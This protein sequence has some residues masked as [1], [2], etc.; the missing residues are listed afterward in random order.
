MHS[1]QQIV[2]VLNASETWFKAFAATVRFIISGSYEPNSI[3]VYIKLQ[4]Q[5]KLIDVLSI[6]EAT[7]VHHVSFKMS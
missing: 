1:V 6:V 2:N 4:Q 7:N 3:R 5:I